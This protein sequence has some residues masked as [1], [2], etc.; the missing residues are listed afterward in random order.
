MSTPGSTSTLRARTDRDDQTP[1]V[2]RVTL[3]L[4]R[5]G[6]L[7]LARA[8][9]PRRR[10]F[11]DVRRALACTGPELRFARALLEG[12]TNL[13]LLRT[14]QRAFGGDFLVIDVSPPRLADRSA[15]VLELKRGLPALRVGP[16]RH[17][18]QNAEAAVD[19][20]ARVTGALL[21]GAPYEVV[22]GDPARLLALL[23]SPGRPGDQNI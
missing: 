3:G 10:D 15:L 21:R 18:V 17:Q 23:C 14:D 20:A 22:F 1:I 12:K 2:V 7:A 13:W 16:T 9:A 6:E 5:Q 19:A 11:S 4:L 8:A